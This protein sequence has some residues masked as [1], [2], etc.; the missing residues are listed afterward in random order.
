MPVFYQNRLKGVVYLENNLS[1]HVFTLERLEILKIL[2]SQAAISI[3]NARLYENM[4][5]KVKERTTQLKNAN[6]KL[7]EQSLHDPLTSLH[8]RRYIYEFIN[9][10]ATKYIHKKAILI[11]NIDKRHTSDKENIIG[12]FLVDIDHFKEVNDTYG[13]LAGDNVLITISKV[14]KSLIRTDDI[15]VRWGGE[16]F[17]IILYNTKPENLEKFS[18]KALEKIK[19][20]PI[21][22]SENETIH[23]TDR[24]S[25]V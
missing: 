21:K 4:E 10:Q 19:G 1:D 11:D 2:S 12:V 15:I 3:E 18:R 8:N 24:K 5:D 6:E 22:V 9:D 16:E 14:L 7:K 25:V 23:K 20:T 13:H 17:L